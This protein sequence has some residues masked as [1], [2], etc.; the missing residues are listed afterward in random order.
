MNDAFL[1]ELRASAPPAPER[2]QA[3]VE[4]IAAREAPPRASWREWLQLRRAVLV[5]APAAL[6]SMLA[7]AV[8]HG[9]FQSSPQRQTAL[10]SS[11]AAQKERAL[12]QADTP[13]PRGSALLSP[14][15]AIIG[16]PSAHRASAGG[17]QTN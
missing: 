5:L 4:A 9:V 17:A 15:M 2:L 13:V 8:A 12:D 16:S 3:R 14:G 10:Q 11:Y 1:A 6:A 7:V